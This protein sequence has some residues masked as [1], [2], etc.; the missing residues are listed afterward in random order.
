MI[1]SENIKYAEKVGKDENEKG[2][3]GGREFSQTFYFGHN[4]I[5]KRKMALVH[6]H[7]SHFIYS[8]KRR[9]CAAFFILI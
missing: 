8:L 4:A 1:T 2:A 3:C 5:N 7:Q 6:A 9:N